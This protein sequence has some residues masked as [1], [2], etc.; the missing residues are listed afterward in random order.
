[1]QDQS[2]WLLDCAE[3]NK[4]HRGDKIGRPFLRHSL[5]QRVRRKYELRTAG[6]RMLLR[7]RVIV[8]VLL[9][10]ATI[11]SVRQ[12]AHAIPAFARKYS[13]PCS[14]CHEAWPKLND[15]GIAFRDR[16]YQLGN[17]K[18][19]PIW[20]NPGYWPITMRITPQWHRESSS[21][22]VVDTVPG[23]PALGQAFQN[24]TTDGFDFGGLDL[25]AA[26]TLYKNISFSVLPSSDSSGSFHFEN[27]F[28]RFDNLFG[29]PWLKRQVR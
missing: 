9:P 15:F 28:V 21:D 23:N 6:I 16:G 4:S 20:Q 10:F 19:S 5:L 2:D 3:T 25:W 1:M 11:L 13:L 29:S 7:P 18:D 22:Q 12:P 24:V 17:E 14:A 8:L 26:G 27:V